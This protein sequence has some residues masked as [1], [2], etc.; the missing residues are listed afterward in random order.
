[1]NIN[2]SFTLVTFTIF[3]SKQKR[4][5]SQ[6]FDKMSTSITPAKIISLLPKIP[7]KHVDELVIHVKDQPKNLTRKRAS[8]VQ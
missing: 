4:P 8:K 5:K 1:M 6:F 7:Q 3:S 2:P